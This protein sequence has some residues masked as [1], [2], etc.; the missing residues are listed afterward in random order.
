MTPDPDPGDNGE[1]K[2]QGHTGDGARGDPEVAEPS[3]E[4][5]ADE[6]GHASDA[7][8]DPDPGGLGTLGALSDQVRS[9]ARWLIGAFAAVGALLVPG[10]QLADLGALTGSR[11]AW[12]LVS[13]GVGLAAVIIAAAAI[14]RVL[15]VK[16]PS[17]AE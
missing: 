6:T 17:F 1:G 16:P 3:T 9:T 11:L 10:L 2:A 14:A 15:S 4:E 8:R 13:A 5:E 12:A 7:E